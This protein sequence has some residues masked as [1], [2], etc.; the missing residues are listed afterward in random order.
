MLSLFVF[1][2]WMCMTEIHFAFLGKWSHDEML[3]GIW[4]PA[5]PMEW[6]GPL[7]WSL[8]YVLDNYLLVLLTMHLHFR[9]TIDKD[10][11]DGSFIVYWQNAPSDLKLKLVFASIIGT[12]I[13]Y[14]IMLAGLA[15]A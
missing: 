12:G 10:I 6:A 5:T 11:N 2:N 7:L 8:P 15:R 9:N 1:T 3:G 14:G 4:R 13:V